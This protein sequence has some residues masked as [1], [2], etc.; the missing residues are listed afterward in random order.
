MV[1]TILEDVAN[2]NFDKV[3][4]MILRML[5]KNNS[6]LD[7]NETDGKGNSL[8]L[9]SIINNINIKNTK[10]TNNNKIIKLL[11]DNAVNNNIDL[12]T[13]AKNNN[14]C[15]LLKAA[16]NNNTE[17]LVSNSLLHS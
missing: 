12:N 13:N 6:I 10:N 8:L 3:K 17:A 4:S 1:N 5:T 11:I 14:D 9:L 2:N 7:F 16:D 15:P